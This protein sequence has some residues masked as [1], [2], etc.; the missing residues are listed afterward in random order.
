MK[1]NIE[2][3]LREVHNVLRAI[4][5]LSVSGTRVEAEALRSR[6]LK[7]L[8]NS[9][10]VLSGKDVL[11][12][13]TFSRSPFQGL[14][15]V[16]RSRSS[17]HERTID[18]SAR[19]NGGKEQRES[20]KQNA[21]FQ[22]QTP[23]NTGDSKGE[24]SRA[25]T[26]N[27][28]LTAPGLTQNYQRPGKTQPPRFRT[29]EDR[30]GTPLSATQSKNSRLVGAGDDKEAQVPAPKKHQTLHSSASKSNVEGLPRLSGPTPLAMPAKR[31]P[32]SNPLP[33][34]SFNESAKA[35]KGNKFR[36]R[37]NA[38][39]YRTYLRFNFQ[40][41]SEIQE[42]LDEWLSGKGIELS[43]TTEGQVTG[44]NSVASCTINE[45]GE[46]KYTRIKL[47]ELSQNGTF[48][49]EIIYSSQEDSCWLWVDIHS[50]SGTWVG[51]PRFM[52]SLLG[53]TRLADGA[54]A[55]TSRVQ[56]VQAGDL[57][58]LLKYLES[59]DR[60]LPVFIACTAHDPVYESF[61][62][63]AEVWAKDTSGI[64]K[65]V[66]LSPDASERAASYFPD[67]FAPPYWS[68]RS[69]LPGLNFKN[70]ADAHRHRFLGTERLASQR[71][72]HVAMILG[73]AARSSSARR[74][75]PGGVRIA[76][77]ALQHRD[78]DI[79]LSGLSA[80]NTQRQVET[81]SATKNS[82]STEHLELSREELENINI[83]KEI[84]GVSA[85]DEDIVLHLAS[86]HEVNASG[87]IG[88][89]D[90]KVRSQESEIDELAMSLEELTIEHDIAQLELTN[91]VNEYHRA[92]SKIRYLTDALSAAGDVESAYSGVHTVHVEPP[93][94]FSELMEILLLDAESE[95]VFTGDQG[96][97]EKLDA[98]DTNGLA[99]THAWYCLESLRDYARLKAENEFHGSIFDFLQNAPEGAKK[100]SPSRFAS[101]E[102]D[103]TMD[104]YGDQR[105]FPVPET[106]SATGQTQ[107]Q[108][109]FKL[110]QIGMKSPRMHVYDNTNG[111]GKIY[112][113]YIG[114]HLSTS[115][116]N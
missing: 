51:T 30:S 110:A 29:T 19:I 58:D 28:R 37:A 5:E 72:S 107:M 76:M 62:Q 111:D 3:E 47:A 57:E 103:T 10:V 102:S 69:Y 81:L 16:P 1:S 67:A 100:V 92:Q 44:A 77:Q 8:S 87:A 31:A 32:I 73:A 6:T 21:S 104:Q 106:V 65:F 49:T 114:P 42:C 36:N 2:E 105:L 83:L 108:A 90:D 4:S 54:H 59:P 14:P 9:T 116:T 70:P 89:V 11:R 46:T 112:I 101:R 53:R 85:L 99:I 64:A 113:G 71:S 55:I 26:Q 97:T 95:V 52:N 66:V 96:I 48:H 60:N 23:I 84:I 18:N 40:Q 109:H 20:G 88:E 98:I 74:S 115:S 78:N 41:K 43:V 15:R 27:R 93:A 33:A 13:R 38:D 39:S 68:I 7:L 63:E 61:V 82:V 75:I 56:L 91:L 94:S 86:V 50:D 22:V 79:L 25:S 34:R 24:P 80:K 17:T 12:L 35:P 45:K